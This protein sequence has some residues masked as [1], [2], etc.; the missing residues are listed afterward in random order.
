MC[1]S[2]IGEKGKHSIREVWK[3]DDDHNDGAAAWLC[4][5]HSVCQFTAAIATQPDKEGFE[6]LILGAL[7]GCVPMQLGRATVVI[8]QPEAGV[9]SCMVGPLHVAK[10]RKRYPLD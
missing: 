10:S 3:L 4:I 8:Q 6:H 7:G 9:E 5:E 2:T 1:P